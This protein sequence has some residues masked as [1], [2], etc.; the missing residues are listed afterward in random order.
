MEGAIE[1]IKNAQEAAK[2]Y[3]LA[4]IKEIEISKYAEGVKV[5]KDPGSSFVLDW[6]KRFAPTFR[7]KYVQ[8]DF[9]DACD[10]LEKILE[11]TVIGD[12]DLK[13]KLEEIK[14]QIQEGIVLNEI[15][16]PTDEPIPLLT[17]FMDTLKP[18][19]FSPERIQRACEMITTYV[20]YVL[21]NDFEIKKKE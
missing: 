20:S 12:P 5:K 13:K 7:K 14:K 10:K 4:Q 1:K 8:K 6:I 16:R 15:P 11:K 2:K 9:E 19:G 3:L 21:K 18:L 17:E